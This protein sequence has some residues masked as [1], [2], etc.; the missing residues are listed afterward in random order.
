MFFRLLLAFTLVPAAEI[1]LLLK[2]GGAI[3]PFNTVV[4]VILT[5]VAGAHLARTQGI[6]AMMAVR[7][8]M[9]AGEMPA[10]EMLDALIVFLAG[11]VLLTPGFLT[12]TAGL[13]L[14][15]PATRRIFKEWLR[16]RFDRW[17]HE[18]RATIRRYP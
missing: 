17:L 10:E 7:T 6:Q 3:G 8:R 14:L 11:V 15:F 13:L 9:D 2:V 4:V 1:Y 12:D 5:A 18:S 16:V